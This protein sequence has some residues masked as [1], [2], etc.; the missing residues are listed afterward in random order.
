MN[1]FSMAESPFEV[2]MVETSLW[3]N[4][5]CLAICCIVAI[6]NTQYGLDT[7]AVGAFQAMPG[8][9]KVFGY[10]DPNQ[11]GGYGIDVSSLT[12]S[13]FP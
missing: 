5:K 10:E 8:F 9:L 4:R 12:C 7:S 2:Q 13:T 1:S 11:P 6:S 3:R